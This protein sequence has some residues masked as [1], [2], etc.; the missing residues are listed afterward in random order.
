MFKLALM[1]RK[2]DTVLAMIRHNQLCGQAIIA[3]LQV[4][5]LVGWV[6]AGSA[7]SWG[8]GCLLLD[9]SGGVLSSWGLLPVVWCTPCS[10]PAACIPPARPAAH[11]ACHVL[12]CTAMYRPSWPCRRRATPRW[13]CT[14]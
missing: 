12:S 14:L 11:P 1:H 2:Y 4:G 6:A 10:S 3:Y 5:G 9:F 8:R 7:A 13:R